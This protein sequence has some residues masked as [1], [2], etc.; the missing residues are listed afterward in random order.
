MC[1]ECTFKN[2][3]MYL[4]CEMCNAKKPGP[5]AKDSQPVA[6]SSEPVEVAAAAAPEV[7]PVAPAQPAAPP[8]AAAAAPPRDGDGGELSPPTVDQSAASEEPMPEEIVARE[9]EAMLSNYCF[10]CRAGNVLRKGSFV[11]DT[12]TL[13]SLQTW[14]STVHNI[15]RE[16]LSLDYRDENNAWVPLKNAADLNAAI[17]PVD[18]GH[19]E[20]IFTRAAPVSLGWDGS[21]PVV[22]SSSPP[23][24]P[25]I[26]ESAMLVSTSAPLSEFQVAEDCHKCKASF[27]YLFSRH[28]TAVPACVP[29]ATLAATNIMRTVHYLESGTAW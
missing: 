26:F 11:R 2:P 13:E 5:E 10:K 15:P 21:P 16:S 9:K 18:E 3:P 14:V 12:F 24:D 7:P 25:A 8:S 1:G 27:G 29:S 23:P 4:T 19:A 20:S 17:A 22:E 6:P 28:T